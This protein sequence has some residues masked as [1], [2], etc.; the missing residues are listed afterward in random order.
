IVHY[1]FLPLKKPATSLRNYS[2]NSTEENVMDSSTAESHVFID[3]VHDGPLGH[4]RKTNQRS[5]IK[6]T[7]KENSYHQTNCMGDQPSS[8]CYIMKFSPNITSSGRSNS[9][10]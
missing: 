3:K 2:S 8:S 7:G 9:P 5:R 1:P 10:E 6:T 4:V